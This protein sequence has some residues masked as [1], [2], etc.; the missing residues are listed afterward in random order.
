[1]RKLC[2]CLLILFQV[3]FVYGQS[4]D[5][6]IEKLTKAVVFLK[7]T[8][9]GFFIKNNNSLYLATASHVAK[10]LN[11]NFTI[12][13]SDTAGKTFS[14]NYINSAGWKVSKFAD[15]AV[16]EIKDSLIRSL[17]YSSAIPISFLP[18]KLTWPDAELP[19]VIIGFPLGL[20]VH[21]N[22][23]PLRRET[24]AASHFVDLPRADNKEIATFVVLQDPSIKGYS[25]APIFIIR[26]Y[27][28]GDVLFKGANAEMC[29][30]LVHGTISDNTGG[31][32]G[33][34]VPEN[35]IYNLIK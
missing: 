19:L 22:F 3:S 8:G 34:A 35:Y 6:S 21:E 11:K 28:F 24:N 10:A 2:L 16:S 13:T 25:G 4:Q 7:D 14:I 26:T 12:I 27:K 30:G 32:L 29:L 33:L 5:L 9:T 31:K 15:V 17:F 20:G 18:Q 23:S 1:L